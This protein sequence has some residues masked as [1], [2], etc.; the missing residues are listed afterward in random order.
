LNACAALLGGWAGFSLKKITRMI[1]GIVTIM[2]SNLKKAMISSTELEELMNIPGMVMPIAI[3]TK[4][5]RT[6][7]KVTNGTIYDRNQ[8]RANRLGVFKIKMPPIDER[9]EPKRQI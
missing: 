7:E 5:A 4:F 9:N 3:E 8:L 1:K 6:P 2:A